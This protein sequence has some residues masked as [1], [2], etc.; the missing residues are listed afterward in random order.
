MDDATGVVVQNWFG[1]LEQEPH[2]LVIAHG[3]DDI[4]TVMSDST[5]YPSP[6]RAIGSNHSTTR[7]GIADGGTVVDVSAMREILE[8]D[9]D[10]VTT[11]AGALYIDVAAALEKVGLQFFVN[12]EL[13]NL[14]MGSAATGG[15]KDASMPGEFGQV[16]SYATEIRLVTPSGGLL[17]V[18][19]GDG[20]LMT[21][22]R[23]SYGL[24]GIVYEVTFRVRPLQS[25]RMEHRSYSLD[26]FID[27][28]PGLRE[29]GDSMMLYLF[30]FINKVVVEFRRYNDDRE[31]KSHWQWWLR[32]TFWSKLNPGWSRFISKYVPGRRFRSLLVNLS[33]R[34]IAFLL[35]FVR[36][37][38]TSPGD[39]MIRYPDKGGF[40]S[41][42]FSIWAFDE[43]RYPEVLAAYYDFCRRH[44]DEHGYRCDML[45]VGYRISH[46]RSQLFSYT[47]DHTVMTLDPV[48]T[49]QDGW[50]D[51]LVAYNEFCSEAGGIPLFNQTKHITPTQAHRAFGDRLAT[52]EA[53]RKRQ[54][55]TDRLL[56]DYFRTTLSL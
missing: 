36:G 46:D 24:L 20:E 8:I 48:S 37:S 10:T 14:T 55:P 34:M 38:H 16:C 50:D 4:V 56:N 45:N 18:D 35:R 28:L 22:M 30:P 3:V 6:V 19:E 27:A 11:Q 25:L 9:E 21:V 5:T 12:I 29:E 1:D 52:F 40:T 43:Q 32:N 39:Q 42:T 15:T 23:S 53:Y 26:G 13:G 7:C 2:V 33:N 17:V 49:G 44:F 31:V 54:D 41:Y 51:F 47:W